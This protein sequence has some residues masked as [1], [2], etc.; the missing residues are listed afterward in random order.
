MELLKELCKIHSPSGEEFR[1][2]EFLIKYIN[3]NK[4]NWK[5]QPQ[6]VYGD[7]FQD[8]LMLVFGKPRTMIFAH[9]DSVGFNVR[10]EKEIIKIG[11]PVTENNTILHGKDKTG[12][13][14]CK[15][16]VN[17]ETKKLSYQY[18]RNIER[19]TSLIFKQEFIEDNE[20]IQSCFLDNRLGIW[21]M[22]KLSET[23]ENGIIAFT[24]WEEHGG[25]SVAVLTKYIYETYKIKNSLIADITWITNGVKPGK[26][27]VISQRDKM[28]PRKKYFEKILSIA[29][30]YNIDYQIEVEENGGS[31]GSELQ[32]LPYPID[33]C[34]IGAAEEN[35]HSPNEKVNKKDVNSMLKLYETLMLN[36]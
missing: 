31:D 11:G 35:V 32:K 29:K 26:G 7:D 1:I 5:A 14:E 18:N 9:M 19:G 12:N 36:L 2:K 6:L 13:I 23:L 20:T 25:G 34:F 21:V 10:Y 3:S 33:W 27:V 24:C 30:D 8:C 28:I 22:L 17:K 15:L 4:Q 16:K